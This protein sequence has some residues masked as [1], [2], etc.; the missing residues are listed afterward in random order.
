MESPYYY[1]LYK[2][3]K[4][5]TYWIIDESDRLAHL[6]KQIRSFKSKHEKYFIVYR[7]YSED[8]IDA[9]LNVEFKRWRSFK[10]TD[11]TKLLFQSS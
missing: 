6:K 10:M 9:L 11:E 4:D 5:N 2:I 7:Q 8:I 1:L 3:P